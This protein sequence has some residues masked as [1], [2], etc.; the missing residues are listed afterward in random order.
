[1]NGA[2]H[3]SAAAREGP[4]RWACASLLYAPYHD[5]GGCVKASTDYNV[6]MCKRM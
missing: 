2:R 3:E 5:R 4:C 6:I 1:L